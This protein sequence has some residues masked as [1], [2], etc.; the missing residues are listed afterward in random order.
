MEKVQ[1]ETLICAATELNRHIRRTESNDKAITKRIEVVEKI[2][3]LAVTMI[4]GLEI[5]EDSYGQ[6]VKNG[7]L[8]FGSF[9]DSIR[10]KGKQISNK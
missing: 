10:V 7:I 5:T 1:K 8:W 2:L 3:Q 6:S 9:F 4:E